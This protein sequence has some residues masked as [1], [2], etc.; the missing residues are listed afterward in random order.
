MRKRQVWVE[1]LFAEGKQWHGMRRFHR[2]RLWRVNSEAL[3]IASGQNLKR[4]LQQRG[5]GRRPFPNGAPAAVNPCD[6]VTL[7][8]WLLVVLAP[9]VCSAQHPRRSATDQIRLVA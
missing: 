1:P 5:W 9:A 7:C 6:V 3:L 4:L 8:L 2:R